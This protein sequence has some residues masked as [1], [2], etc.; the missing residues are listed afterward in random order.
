MRSVLAKRFDFYRSLDVNYVSVPDVVRFCPQNRVY[1][2]ISNEREPV[3]L[4][5]SKMPLWTLLGG[6]AV[7]RA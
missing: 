5:R 3:R 7:M 1:K 2:D 6:G 4:V